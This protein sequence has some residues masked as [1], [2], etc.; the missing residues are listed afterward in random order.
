[1]KYVADKLLQRV[2]GVNLGDITSAL[3]R[4][5]IPSFIPHLKPNGD[6][7]RSYVVMVPEEYLSKVPDLKGHSGFI[8]KPHA[9]E[10]GNLFY[11]SSHKVFNEKEARKHP[12]WKKFRRDDDGNLVERIELVVW[13]DYVP[14]DGSE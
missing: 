10:N 14:L 7:V 3:T 13:D 6:Y 1:M 9:E 5:S 2:S 8:G 4:A 11:Y 12:N